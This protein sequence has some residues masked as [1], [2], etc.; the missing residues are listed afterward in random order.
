MDGSWAS[1]PRPLPRAIK[2]AD[3]LIRLSKIA[4]IKLKGPR[5]FTYLLA[6]RILRLM[7]R[8][9]RVAP[10]QMLY[11]VFN[12]ANGRLR[13]DRKEADY[14]SFYDVLRQTQQR[15]PLRILG[16]CLMAN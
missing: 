15:V 1:A 16:W 11:H 9:A 13:L 2:W 3:Q 4:G 8:S 5:P 7:P 14:L 12:R 6:H 10:G